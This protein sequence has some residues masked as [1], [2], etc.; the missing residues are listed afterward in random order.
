MSCI[1]ASI[2]TAAGLRAACLV[3]RVCIVLYMTLTSWRLVAPLIVMYVAMIVEWREWVVAIV[4]WRIIAPVVWRPIRNVWTWAPPPVEY[5]RVIYI[6]R[7]YD[8]VLTIDVRVTNNCHGDIALLRHCI[9]AIRLDNQSCHILIQ[10][11]AKHSLNEHIT[12]VV[13]GHFDH[14]E[15]VNKAIFVEVEVRNWVLRVVQSLLKSLKI[16]SLA[17]G[18]CN[19]L[20]VEIISHCVVARGD[21]YSTCNLL[22]VSHNTCTD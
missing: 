19:R 18:S 4:V 7:N 11:L 22:C 16:L 8:I 5:H 6:S 15:V 2:V 1:I 21:G 13:L 20:K 12:L 17:K 9:S 3:A 14:A 10:I